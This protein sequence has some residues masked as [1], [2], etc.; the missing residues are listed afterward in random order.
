MNYGGDDR[1]DKFCPQTRTINDL[2]H[3][4]GPEWKQTLDRIEIQPKIDHRVSH[5]IAC[6][7]IPKAILAYLLAFVVYQYI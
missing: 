6:P 2:K 3:L 5:N 1:A 7:Y 4:Y